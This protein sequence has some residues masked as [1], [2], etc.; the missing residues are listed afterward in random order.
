MDTPSRRLPL[1]VTMT[2]GSNGF[3]INIIYGRGGWEVAYPVIPEHPKKDAS[4]SWTFGPAPF[5]PG[6]VPQWASMP[7]MEFLNLLAEEYKLPHV[8]V[9]NI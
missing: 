7:L 2:I 9:A 6:H 8:L 5:R 1:G 3:Q 4:G